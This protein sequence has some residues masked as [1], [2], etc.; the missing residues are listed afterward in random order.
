MQQHESNL[1]RHSAVAHAWSVLGYLKLISGDYVRSKECLKTAL[2]VWAEVKRKRTQRS[3]MS[4]NDIVNEIVTSPVD[5][6]A[7]DENELESTK[8]R[9]SYAV[10]KHLKEREKRT[11]SFNALDDG[12]GVGVGTSNAKMCC[13][14]M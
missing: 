5:Y 2:D 3:L 4:T 7:I 13:V 14:I 12:V 9:L 8:K 6:F 11:N 10:S 1:V